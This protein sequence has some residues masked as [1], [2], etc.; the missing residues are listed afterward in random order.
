MG[1]NSLVGLAI[2]NIHRDRDIQIDEVIDMF[3]ATK[4][5]IIDLIL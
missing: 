3:A 4:K 1:Q 2:L 5:R